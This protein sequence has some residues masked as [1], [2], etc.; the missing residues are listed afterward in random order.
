MRVRYDS[1]LPVVP[2][3]DIVAEAPR[4]RDVVCI[5][6]QRVWFGV[7][8]PSNGVVWCVGPAKG[9]D[10]VCGS[11]QRMWF[12]GNPVPVVAVAD[13]VAEAPRRGPEPPLILH[14]VMIKDKLTN[15]CGS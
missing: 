4:P 2:V 11:S 7:Y 14:T 5:V 15:L 3:A 12:G 10:L 8:S 9:C 1:H 13:I 6:R